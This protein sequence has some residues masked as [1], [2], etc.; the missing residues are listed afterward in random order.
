MST[1]PI[2]KKLENAAF[3]SACAALVIAATVFID[4]RTPT[5]QVSLGD[6]FLSLYPGAEELKA[7]TWLSQ[8][9]SPQPGFLSYSGYPMP[10]SCHQG[11]SQHDSFGNA[12]YLLNQNFCSPDIRSTSAR[13]AVFSARQQGVSTGQTIA[14]NGSRA[15]TTSHS[16]TAWRTADPCGK[17]CKQQTYTYHGSCSNPKPTGASCVG[18]GSAT[19]YPF[20]YSTQTYGSQVAVPPGTPVTLEWSCQNTQANAVTYVWS[21]CDLG[22]CDGENTHLSQTY[23]LANRSTGT[24]FSTGNGLTGTVTVSP[25]QNTTYTLSCGGYRYQPIDA[26][27]NST[28]NGSSCNVPTGYASGKVLSSSMHQSVS[29]TV[30]MGSPVP[31]VTTNPA[32]SVGATTATFNGAGNPNGAAATGW[33]RYAAS[34]PGSC[35]DSFGTRVPASSG[36]SLGS[37]SS[38]VSYNQGVSGLSA[39]TTYYYCA[40]AQNSGG[41]G[42]GAVQSFS[43]SADI[44]TDITGNQASLP[45]NCT[46]TP[47][48]CLGAGQQWSGTQ[49]EAIPP[50]ISTFEALPNRVRAGESTQLSWQVENAPATCTLSGTDGFSEEVVGASGTVD[51]DPITA[52]TVFT[53]ACGATSEQIVVT[54]VPEYQEI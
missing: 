34:N 26:D 50:T 35:S 1:R 2:L 47:P 18:I 16:M 28:C 37:G 39:A 48:S 51:T 25:T 12:Q 24:N 42:Y 52:R 36:T 17:G 7:A 54:I 20:A 43:T 31:T 3:F 19:G 40:I 27:V 15:N 21:D 14:L 10:A 29:L 33:F 46:G 13:L 23:L 38:A 44:C 53:L 8:Q 32:T 41:L 9:A 22:W 49:C 6:Y 5:A 11:N 4:Q 30:V 45:P